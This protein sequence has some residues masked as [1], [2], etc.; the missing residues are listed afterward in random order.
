[1]GLTRNS[2]AANSSASFLFV[3][4]VCLQLRYN[5]RFPVTFLVP[6]ARAHYGLLPRMHRYSPPDPSSVLGSALR[7]LFFIFGQ[8]LGPGT[9]TYVRPKRGIYVPATP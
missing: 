7:D 6:Q 1:M 9:L 2:S 4:V 3:A 5:W 8:V